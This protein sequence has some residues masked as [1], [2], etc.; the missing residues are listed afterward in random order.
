MTDNEILVNLKHDLQISATSLDEYLGDII[1]LAKRA[2]T[3]EGITLADDVPDGMLVEMYAAF[4]YRKRREEVYTM[5]RY[6]RWMLN[7]RVFSEKAKVENG[8]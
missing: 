6:L 2:I 7:N 1:T 8:D 3:T 5:P 4:L